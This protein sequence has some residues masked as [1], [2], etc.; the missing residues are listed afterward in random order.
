MDDVYAFCECHAGSAGLFLAFEAAFT[1]ALGAMRSKS[2]YNGIMC[3]FDL[4]ALDY[5]G[6]CSHSSMIESPIGNHNLSAEELEAK[7]AEL[8][9]R[10]KE[11]QRE[12][13]EKTKQANPDR[14]NARRK[15]E[16]RLLIKRDPKEIV[17][18]GKMKAVAEKRHHCTTCNHTFNTK[19]ALR[20]HLAG[21]KHAAKVAEAARIKK[22][23]CAVCDYT[24]NGNQVLTKHF[25]SQKHAANACFGAAGRL[26][27]VALVACHF[28]EHLQHFTILT[29]Y[30]IL[31]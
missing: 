9:D 3:Q 10:R 2:E 6:L 15:E 24:A 8:A 27:I 23:Y 1:F 11:Y 19:P 28:L 13:R 12:W 14:N 16:R 29:P 31:H 22:F 30:A 17:K 25:A 21:P 7:A 4:D 18:R 20:K 26:V 5:D